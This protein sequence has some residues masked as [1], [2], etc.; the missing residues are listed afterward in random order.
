MESNI[1][2]KQHNKVNFGKIVNTSFLAIFLLAAC[3]APVADQQASSLEQTSLVTVYKSASCSCCSKWSEYLEESGFTVLVEEVDDFGDVKDRFQV[4]KEL[5]S[6]HTAIVD[7]YV[8]EGHVPVSEIARLL[9][10]RPDIIGIAVP[11]MPPGSPGMEVDGL[12]FGT[13]DVVAFDWSGGTEIFSSY[14]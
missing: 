2:M 6:C 12:A 9:E 10:E 13:F 1:E 14:P 3:A 7:G 4:P 8:V 5:Q 11:G